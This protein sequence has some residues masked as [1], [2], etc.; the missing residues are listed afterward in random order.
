MSSLLDQPPLTLFDYQYPE[1]SISVGYLI[2]ASS[3]ICIPFYMVY[4][5]VWT[6][7]SLKQVRSGV[8]DPTAS[9]QARGGQGPLLGLAQDQGAGQMVDVSSVSLFTWQFH[10]T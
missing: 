6:P 7:G 1:W 9:A 8:G 4:K 10:H 5:L 3:F 2:G